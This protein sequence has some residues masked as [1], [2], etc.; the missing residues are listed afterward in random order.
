MVRRK[1]GAGLA[2]VLL[3]LA[4]L[5]SYAAAQENTTDDWTDRAEELAN[6]SSFEEAISALDEALKVDPETRRS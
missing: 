1:A 6:N 3:A 4:A 2:L 5:C